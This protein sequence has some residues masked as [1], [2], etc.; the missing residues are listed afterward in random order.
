[1]YNPFIFRDFSIITVFSL[2]F[3]DIQINYLHVETLSKG[4]VFLQKL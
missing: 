2:I 1:M 4:I 3:M